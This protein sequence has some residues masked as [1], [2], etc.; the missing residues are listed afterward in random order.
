MRH[1]NYVNVAFFVQFLKEF[2]LR[3]SCKKRQKIVQY[4]SII[5]MT[6]GRF[7]R[8]KIIVHRKKGDLNWQQVKNLPVKEEQI[9]NHP[10]KQELHPQEINLRAELIF[11][12]IQSSER[13]LS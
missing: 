4:K 12:R 9:K 6:M 13:K 2:A 1:Q 3:L 7:T 10:I 5:A 11:L 8:H